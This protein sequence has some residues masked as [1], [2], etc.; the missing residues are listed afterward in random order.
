MARTA[1][2]KACEATEALMA[3]LLELSGRRI[4]SGQHNY[5]GTLSAHTEQTTRLAG[6]EPAVWGQDFGFSDDEQDGIQ[7]RGAIVQEAVRQYRRGSLVTLMW[8]AVPPTMDEP[9]SFKEGVQSQ[10]T[11]EEWLRLTTPGTPLHRRW[12]S[13]VDRIA[14]LLRE[15]KE[16]GVVVVWRPYHESNG[17]WFWWG[18]RPGPEGSAKLYRMLFE[19]LTYEHGL[20]NLLWVYNPNAP[21]SGVLPYECMFPGHDV[22]D[23]LATDIYGGEFPDSFHDDLL[24]LADGR[25]IA[26]GEVGQLPPPEVLDRQTRYVWFMLWAGME[27]KW[28]TPEG[29]RSVFH[30]PRTMN[31]AEW[32]GF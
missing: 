17:R 12:A 15:L 5:P 9:V 31:H 29:L 32:A 10:L 7:F 26:I 13:Q 8:H 20:D 22:V 11:D 14:I 18:G 30:H 3:R 6:A 27:T 23:V 25:P 21:R 19:R 28:N 24:A 2:P 4:L 16:A 1:N